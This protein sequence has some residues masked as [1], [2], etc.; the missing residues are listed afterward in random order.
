VSKT[1]LVNP[2]FYR[3]LG[4]RYNA[5]S[6]G[7]AYVAKKIGAYI[8][9]ADFLDKPCSDL[10][11]I[12]ENETNYLNYFQDVDHD[13][14][15]E[16]VNKILEFE[17]EVIGYTCYTANVPTINIIS[18]KIYDLDKNIKQV[19]GGSHLRL[20]ESSE[21]FHCFM[22][23][24]CG[25]VDPEDDFPER[26]NFWGV[27]EDQKKKIDNSYI[28]TSFGCPY[29]C[30]FCASPKIWNRRVK[31]RSIDSVIEEMIQ[32]KERYRIEKFYILD[33]VFTVGTKRVK[34]ILY[35]MKD[36]NVEWMCN[37]R[38]D[39]LTEDV[40]R[41]MKESGCVEAKVGIESGSDCLLKEMNKMETKEEMIR[42]INFL[43]DNDISI[44]GYFIAGLPTETDKDLK[45]TIEFAK[46]INI[47]RYSLS[48]FAPYYG[49]KIY[50]D[51]EDTLKDLSYEYF[52]HQNKLVAN[53]IISK[54]IF[55]EYLDLSDL[56][57]RG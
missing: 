5:N 21:D 40:C 3:L 17:P 31:F 52:Y 46:K 55:Q 27:S 16:V 1:L 14:W 18:K 20:K 15:K 38:L 42:G 43:K 41:L 47:D 45:E 32:M 49:S 30:S 35:R 53:K 8:Y 37:T 34:E 48:V 29:N 50:F 56:N 26:E 11:N 10:G 54:E 57:K 13:I 25:W 9:N 7:L 6:L 12:F 44:T 2:P 36:L 24:N 22:E 51:I 23:A 33:D 19:V 4:S 28:I 39:S